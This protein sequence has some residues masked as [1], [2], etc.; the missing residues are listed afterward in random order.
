MISAQLPDPQLHPLL[1]AKVIKY[2]LHGPCGAD[3]PQA[4]CMVNG[5]CSKCFPKDYREK[6][7]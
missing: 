3:D 2:M 7:D 5:Q 1:Y 6:T 4:K